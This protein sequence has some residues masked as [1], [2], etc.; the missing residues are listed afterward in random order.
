MYLIYC[1]ARPHR[2]MCKYKH[3]ITRKTSIAIRIASWRKYRDMYLIAKSGIVTTLVGPTMKCIELRMYKVLRLGQTRPKMVIYTK[4][5]MTRTHWR[6][7]ILPIYLSASPPSPVTPFLGR[8][9]PTLRHVHNYCA[10]LLYLQLVSR[11][12]KLMMKLKL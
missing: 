3:W 9:F 12:R 2:K 7:H 4:L 8:P 5:I 1:I 10:K 6:R 11:I